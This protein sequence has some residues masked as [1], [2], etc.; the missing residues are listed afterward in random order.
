M[1]NFHTALLALHSSYK[2]PLSAFDEICHAANHRNNYFTL[3]HLHVVMADRLL[4]TQSVRERWN[5]LKLTILLILTSITV[6]QKVKCQCLGSNSLKNM[7]KSAIGSH[8]LKILVQKRAKRLI[9][10]IAN[11]VTNIPQL[12]HH[13]QFCA[14]STANRCKLTALVTISS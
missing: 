12:K 14:I 4:Y 3:T 11:M 10:D 5:L 1:I 9:Q 8:R 2:Q 7:Y 6:K 13:G